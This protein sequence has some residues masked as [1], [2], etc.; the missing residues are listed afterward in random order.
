MTPSLGKFYGVGVGPGEPGLIPVAALRALQTCDLILAPR[1]ESAAFSVARHCLQGLEIPE[2]RFREIEFKMSPNRDILR[3]HYSELAREIATELCAGR[4][5]G[6]LTI[7]D[8]MTYSTY[9]Y[10]LA[11]LLDELPQLEHRTFPGITSYAAVAA[12]AEWPLG[13]GKERMLILPC[14]E[15]MAELEREIHANDIVIL[16]KVGERLARVLEL[17]SKLGIEANCAFGSRIGLPGGMVTSNLS[18]LPPDAGY[19][20]TMLIRRK[21]REQRHLRDLPKT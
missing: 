7:G 6:Y 10:A 8:S 12:A 13:E 15:D 14:P 20:S 2:E 11:A 17:V 16:M 21:A 5:V 4:T 19:L 9:G 1:A 18:Q 3:Q